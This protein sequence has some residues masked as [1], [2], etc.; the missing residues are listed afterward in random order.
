MERSS[1]NFIVETM[2]CHALHYAFDQPHD[3]SLSRPGCSSTSPTVRPRTD[4]AFHLGIRRVVSLRACG[5]PCRHWTQDSVSACVRSLNS[6]ACGLRSP[7]RAPIVREGGFLTRVLDISSWV[8]LPIDPRNSHS[9]LL[10]AQ[11]VRR[12]AKLALQQYIRKLE[13]ISQ[14]RLTDFYRDRVSEVWSIINECVEFTVLAT[15][16]DRR[17]QVFQ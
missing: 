8:G 14:N 5:R 13:P 10:L 12:Q 2:V 16:V 6:H 7:T 9:C 1:V 3:L 4:L 15:R 11:T 17:W